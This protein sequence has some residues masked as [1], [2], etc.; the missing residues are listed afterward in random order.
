M[1]LKKLDSIHSKE[2][3]EQE[4]DMIAE[5]DSENDSLFEL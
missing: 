4:I 5:Y 2:L 1:K 3:F